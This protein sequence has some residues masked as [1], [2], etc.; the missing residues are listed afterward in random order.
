MLSASCNKPN[1]DK[2]K[3]KEEEEET[4]N[5]LC[6]TGMGGN[7]GGGGG[8]LYTSLYKTDHMMYRYGNFR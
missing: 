4:N 8:G 5:I 1:T 2:I 7:G 6:H 3:T